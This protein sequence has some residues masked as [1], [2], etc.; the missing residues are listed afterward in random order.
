MAAGCKLEVELQA[1]ASQGEK[2]DEEVQSYDSLVL[3]G[4]SLSA[5]QIKDAAS[6]VA[7]LVQHIKDGKEV[8][9]VLKK[10]LDLGA[11]KKGD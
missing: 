10:W 8:S 2:I 1:L 4:K 6:V 3:Q 11:A 9:D 7:K 5:S